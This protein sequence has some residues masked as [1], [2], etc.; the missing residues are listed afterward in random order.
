MINLNREIRPEDFK[1]DCERTFHCTPEGEAELR[2]YQNELEE[3]KRAYELQ[4]EAKAKAHYIREQ[5]R[6]NQIPY[7]EAL[8]T[9]ICERISAG[10]VLWNICKD[11]DMP[12]VRS[13]NRWLKEH[14]DFSA[15]HKEAVNDRLNVFEDQIVTISD[16]FESDFKTVKKAGKATRVFDAEVVSRA[17]LRI[18][19]RKAHLKAYRPEKWGDT[20]TLITKSVDD[21]SELS[22][23]ELE[24][25]LGELEA[26][27]NVVR[28]A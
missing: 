2:A 24:K 6:K 17:K 25:K 13:V 4:E 26:K 18:D 1:F 10:E 28:A 15:L 5:A 20:S 22:Q 14:A 3:L 12:T 27:D 11:S 7:S 19:V 16:E 21:V 23:D 9:E 8:V